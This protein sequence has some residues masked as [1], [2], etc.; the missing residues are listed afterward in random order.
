MTVAR[1]CAVRLKLNFG[2]EEF[3]KIISKDVYP[4][5]RY[6]LTVLH[7]VNDLSQPCVVSKTG[8]EPL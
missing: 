3:K 6:Y 2:L 7:R 8:L 1:N 5:D 4:A